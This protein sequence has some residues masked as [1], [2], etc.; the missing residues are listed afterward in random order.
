MIGHYGGWIVQALELLDA[1]KGSEMVAELERL[2]DVLAK[3]PAIGRRS[4][5]RMAMRLLSQPSHALLKQIV[6]ALQDADDGLALCSQCG[7]ITPA[8]KNPCRIC[9]DPRRDSSLLCVVE[10]PGDL[11]IM[12]SAHGFNGR[13]HVLGGKLSAARKQGPKSIR[14]PRLLERIEN[15]GVSEILLALNTNVE[16]DATVSYLRELLAERGVSVSRIAM[17]LPAGSGI[18]YADPITLQRAVEARQKMQ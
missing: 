3:L 12:E 7:A 17:G 13:Y 18:S 8:A 16:S 2:V 15:E 14:V 9:S 11:E 6:S 5:Q 1:E 10:S 4:A